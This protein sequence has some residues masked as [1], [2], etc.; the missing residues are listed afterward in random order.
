MDWS[1]FFSYLPTKDS[2][3]QKLNQYKEDAK[4]S[5]IG[6]VSEYHK[7]DTPERT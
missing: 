7:K 4:A 2:V 5:S 1:K 3:H 6:P